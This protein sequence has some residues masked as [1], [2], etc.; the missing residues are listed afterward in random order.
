LIQETFARR[1][2]EARLKAGYSQK[3]LGI[4]AGMDAFS[5]SSRM[6]HYEKGRHLPDL[7]MAERIASILEVPTAYLFCPEPDLAE[8][9]LAIWAVDPAEFP[10]IKRYLEG[11][12][13]SAGRTDG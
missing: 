1:L 2:K 12:R 7:S 11:K 9:L 4:M 3:T 8:M 6:N 13:K 5:A 10:R